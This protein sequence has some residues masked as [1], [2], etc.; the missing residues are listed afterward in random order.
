MSEENSRSRLPVIQFTVEKDK[1]Q[2]GIMGSAFERFRSLKKIIQ[3]INTS[4][5]LQFSRCIVQ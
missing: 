2:N 4:L 5:T 1:K 3:V